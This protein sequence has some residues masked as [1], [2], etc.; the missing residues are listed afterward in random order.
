MDEGNLRGSVP[1]ESHTLCV[2]AFPRGEVKENLFRYTT[3][4]SEAQV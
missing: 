1:F 3:T 2:N 4:W